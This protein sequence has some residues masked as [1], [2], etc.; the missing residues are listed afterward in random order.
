VEFHQRRKMMKKLVF[1]L[2]LIA[3]TMSASA[4]LS[5]GGDGNRD[6][7]RQAW[8]EVQAQEK[9]QAA[10]EKAAAEKAKASS[11]ETKSKNER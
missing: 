6:S 4:V 3:F 1:A 9:K 8:K 2:T 5:A 7:L 11:S 10:A